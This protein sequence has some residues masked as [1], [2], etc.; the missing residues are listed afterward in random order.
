MI[1][2]ASVLQNVL[3]LAAQHAVTVQVGA[4]NAAQTVQAAIQGVVG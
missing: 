4:L 2:I 1:A 3:Q